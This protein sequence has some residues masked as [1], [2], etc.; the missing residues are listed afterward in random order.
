MV[1]YWES[2]VPPN[3]FL[4]LPVG[5]HPG[6]FF[7]V[8]TSSQIVLADLFLF[9]WTTNV[10]FQNFQFSWNIFKFGFSQGERTWQKHLVGEP[11]TLCA[12]RKLFIINLFSLFDISNLSFIIRSLCSLSSK[13]MAGIHFTQYF[14]GSI[15]E[16]EWYFLFNN[17]E[18]LYNLKLL[19]AYFKYCIEL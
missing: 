12:Y 15:Q 3:Y 13:E 11:C 5:W 6:W 18:R 1:L 10:R 4:I 2:E 9:T 19:K 8:S 16:A 7:K 14:S 17:G